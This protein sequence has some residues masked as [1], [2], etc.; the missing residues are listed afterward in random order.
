MSDGELPGGLPPLGLVAGGCD[1]DVDGELDARVLAVL[2]ERPGGLST[3][4]VRGAVRGRDTEI[5]AALQRLES[6]GRA[7]CARGPRGAFVWRAEG[8][9][10]RAAEKARPERGPAPGHGAPEAD[11]EPDWENRS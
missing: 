6:A 11:L 3:R 5:D 8:S 2:L 9:W 10:S 1:G 4:Q 7:T